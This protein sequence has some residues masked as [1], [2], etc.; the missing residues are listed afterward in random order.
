MRKLKVFNS[1]SLD[2]YFCDDSGDMSWAHKDDPE[3][4]EF[5]SGNASGGTLLFGR[6]T[7]QVMA[8]YW[9]SKQAREAAPD[10]ARGMNSVEKVVFSRTLAEASWQNTALVKKDVAGHVR[11]MKKR[12]GPDLVILGSGTIVSQLTEAGLIDEYQLVLV[13]VVLGGGRTM[14]E[15]VTKPPQLKLRKSR[16]FEYG[17][18]VLWLSKR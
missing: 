15:G 13:P 10:V 3:W 4:G 7:Y 16:T 18:V 8:G 14:F 2:G 17:N 11:K 9:T 6:V 12:S 5:V 1:V